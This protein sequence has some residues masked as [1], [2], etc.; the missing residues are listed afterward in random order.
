MQGDLE[1]LLGVINDESVD[2]TLSG[3]I[4]DLPLDAEH[5]YH[6]VVV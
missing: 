6:L 5:P 1:D 4:P 2:S 3:G